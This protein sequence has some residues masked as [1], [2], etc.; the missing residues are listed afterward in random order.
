MTAPTPTR[1]GQPPLQQP[2]APDAQILPPSRHKRRPIWLAAAVLLVALG[3]LGVWFVVSNL[4]DTVAVVALRN[5]VPRGTAITAQDL[6]T[7]DINP[8]PALRTVP[9]S[10]LAQVVGKQAAVDLPAGTL[11]SPA[12]I[13]DTITP[14]AG[15][16]VVGLALD[17]GQMPAIELKVGDKVRIISTPKDQDD[18]PTTAP[19]V[20]VSAE[21]V[22]STPLADTSKTRVDVLVSEQ[23]A[24]KVAAIS[25]TNR[26]ALILDN[27]HR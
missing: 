11:L 27:T 1:T 5:D 10:Q 19:V 25:A 3:S 20:T 13:A 12:G 16:S 17:P 24:A 8:E 21:V 7:V 14:P 9:A 6:T 22:S 15:Q 2:A 26:V 4:R 18:P 23:D